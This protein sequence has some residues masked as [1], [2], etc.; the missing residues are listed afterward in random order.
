MEKKRVIVFTG[1]YRH[2]VGHVCAAEIAAALAARG[3]NVEMVD[4]R[5]RDH[6]LAAQNPDFYKGA[7]FALG[8]NNYRAAG[9]HR[10]FRYY[11]QTGCL[12][13]TML[14]RNPFENI[15]GSCGCSDFLLCRDRT[16]VASM[17][18]F[19]VSMGALLATLPPGASNL[20]ISAIFMTPIR[21]TGS[22]RPFPN[23]SGRW[24]T[25]SSKFPCPACSSIPGMPFPPFLKSAA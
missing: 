18:K 16:D 19:F 13:V 21:N 24:S 7:F 11:E 20:S 6:C 2:N 3:F 22:C 12:F 15:H 25:R 9:F 8:V 4:L 1:H 10:L 17:R 14:L 5:L 23:I